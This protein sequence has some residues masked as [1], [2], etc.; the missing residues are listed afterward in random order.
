MEKNPFV[1]G[2]NLNG[3]ERLVSYPYDMARTPSQEQLLAEALAA[4]RGEDDDEASEAQETPD[5]A[6]FRWLAISFAS[7]HLTM[8]EPYRGGCQAQDYTS[9]MGIVNGA[10]WNPRSGSKSARGRAWERCVEGTGEADHRSVLSVQLSM[11]SATCTLTAW[12]SPCTWAVTSSPTRV[13]CPENGRTTKR[14]CL[15][16]W[17]RWDN[18]GCIEG[19]MKL[20]R[21][22]GVESLCG[23]PL[24]LPFE[25]APWH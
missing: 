11:T 2:A 7:A 3:G 25:G 21:G 17:S 20:G 12:S 1:L 24:H 16:S 14:H 18:L 10:K 23:L 15:P 4:A 13:S 22:I 19:G 9:G 6:I 5:H 8:T